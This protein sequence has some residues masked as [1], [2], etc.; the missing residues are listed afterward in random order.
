MQKNTIDKQLK[1]KMKDFKELSL[2]MK[3]VSSFALSY[4]FFL[5]VL[6]LLSLVFNQYVLDSKYYNIDDPSKSNDVL[7]LVLNLLITTCCIVSL[8]LIF[9]KKKWG[10]WCFLVSTLVLIVYQ[11]ITTG[12]DVWSRYAIELLVMILITG[13][14]VF[15]RPAKTTE[16][17]ATE[18]II[19]SK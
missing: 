3:L 14:R 1:T 13:L 8:I 7:Q 16:L 17:G 6:A 15:Q 19:E 11:L 2:P 12:T 5:F 18:E 4:Y 9:M 10:K